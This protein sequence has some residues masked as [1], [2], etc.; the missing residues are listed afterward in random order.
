MEVDKE[1]TRKFL[2][3]DTRDL[4]SDFSLPSRDGKKGQ[5]GGEKKDNISRKGNEKRVGNP[6]REK[7]NKD[8]EIDSEL[9]SKRLNP[10]ERKER[11][12][13]PKKQNR[14][15]GESNILER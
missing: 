12:E 15:S 8:I 2:N 3:L 1:S 6:L 4:A 9:P 14:K 5:R 11:T 7:E 13:K 10:G